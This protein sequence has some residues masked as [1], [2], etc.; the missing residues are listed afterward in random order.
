M[1]VMPLASY[2]VYVNAI[3]YV[4]VANL[5]HVDEIICVHELMIKSAVAFDYVHFGKC[6]GD[7]DSDRYNVEEQPGEYV[8]D[9]QIASSS[10][11][12]MTRIEFDPIWSSESN[13][14]Q[15]KRDQFSFP[16]TQRG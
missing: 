6:K 2:Y 4:D 11:Q 9:F 15:K 16:I 14:V 12:K 7:D 10:A 3:A 13:E 8:D 5:V 1:A